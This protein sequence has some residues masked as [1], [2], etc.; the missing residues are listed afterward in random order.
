MAAIRFDRQQLCGSHRNLGVN[1]KQAGAYIF[2]VSIGLF[3]SH[4]FMHFIYTIFL[5]FLLFFEYEGFTHNFCPHVVGIFLPITKIS[6]TDF[7]YEKPAL[8]H[9]M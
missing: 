2:L 1:S 4:L 3:L 7:I 5:F 6:V 9:K 8:G